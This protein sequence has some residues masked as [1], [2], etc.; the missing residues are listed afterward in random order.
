MSRIWYPE[1]IDPEDPE[2]RFLS[3]LQGIP[4]VGRSPMLLQEKMA[5]AISKHLA[6][7]GVPAPDPEQASK[8]LQRPYRGQQSGF[9]GMIRWVP[10]DTEDPEPIVIQDPA[11]MTV[12]EREAQVERMRYLGYKVDEP[13]DKAPT[14]EVVSLPVVSG[15]DPGAHSVTEVVAYLRECGAPTE[16]GRVLSAERIGKARNGILKRFP[17]GAES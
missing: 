13:A 17:K 11:L 7:C 6:E 14:A 8:K 16:V 10:L 3:V 5:R 1:D 15:F 2:Q 4:M 12:Q 9:N